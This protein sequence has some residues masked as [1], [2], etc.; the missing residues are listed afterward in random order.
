MVFGTI[1]G[2]VQSSCLMSLFMFIFRVISSCKF[3][4]LEFTSD[5][6]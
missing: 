1:F 5:S 4:R 6:T 2:E 3:K